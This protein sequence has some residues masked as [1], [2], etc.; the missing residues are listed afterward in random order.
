MVKMWMAGI[1]RLL[2]SGRVVHPYVDVGNPSGAQ[3]TIVLWKFEHQSQTTKPL[4]VVGK[5]T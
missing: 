1:T 5:G 2:K 4:G 3:V